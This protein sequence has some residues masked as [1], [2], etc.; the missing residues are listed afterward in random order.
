MNSKPRIPL[1]IGIALFSIAVVA[2]LYIL[3]VEHRD[4]GF[5]RDFP[6]HVAKQLNN[7]DLGY[8]SYYIAG[9]TGKDLYL[10]NSTAPLHLLRINQ[11]LTDSQ[12]ISLRLRNGP[13]RLVNPRITIDSPYFYFSD[14]SIPVI[15]RGDM[16]N[17]I[18]V[19]L[20][21]DSPSFIALTAIS[22][23]SMVIR[24]RD[25]NP[26]PEEYLLAKAS[27]MPSTIKL[28]PTLLEKQID[29]KFCT[30]G[31]MHYNAASN[32]F[33]YLYYYRNE[34]LV[35]DSNLNLRYRGHTVDTVSQAK[36]AVGAYGRGDSKTI[37]MAA[38]PQTVNKH[39]SICGS[40]LFVHSA[41]RATNENE[42]TFKNSSVIDVYD[43]VEN[44]YRFS[45]HLPRF[46]GEEM[47]GFRVVQNQLFALY[48]T[49]LV[50][51][52]LSEDYFDQS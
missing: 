2:A 19:P 52:R 5:I 15:T 12:H 33:V 41:L 4:N 39:S 49:Q 21:E 30:D 25:L 11:Q 47:R 18:A 34:Y 3:S 31:M 13:D 16:T 35:T 44:R 42:N 51:Y 14:G 43:L 1:L 8:N 20:A 24:N 50:V 48:G 7:Y 6:P 45:F 29:G 36:I 40:W 46:N 9:H 32:R 22:P 26:K 23:T 37:T 38:P 27:F 28:A 10:G 17:W